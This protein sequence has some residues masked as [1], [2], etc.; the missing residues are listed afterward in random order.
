MVLSSTKYVVGEKMKSCYFASISALQIS[1]MKA[2]VGFFPYGVDWCFGHWNL[3]RIWVHCIHWD[4][5]LDAFGC[6]LKN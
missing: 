6:V 3:K 2:L 5:P 1:D 4:T